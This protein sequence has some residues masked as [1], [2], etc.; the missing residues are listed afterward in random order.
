MNQIWGL[1]IREISRRRNVPRTTVRDI[2][3]RKTWTHV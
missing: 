3:H 1:S 2:I